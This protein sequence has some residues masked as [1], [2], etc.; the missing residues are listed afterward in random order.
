MIKGEKVTPLKQILDKKGKTMHM[1]KF[2]HENFKK[3]EKYFF[4]MPC[5]DL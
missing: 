5:Q 3:F 2:N 4:H 1:M